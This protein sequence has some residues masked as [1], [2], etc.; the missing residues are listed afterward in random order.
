[1]GNGFLM[2]IIPCPVEG[3]DQDNEDG[4]PVYYIAL[5]DVWYGEH[6]IKRAAVK[7]N[8]P[9]GHKVFENFYLAVALCDDYNLPNLPKNRDLWELEKMN[10]KILTWVGMTFFLDYNSVFQVKKKTYS[11]SLNGT[12]E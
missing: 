7:E 2:R 3:C 9:E 1:M 11:P 6:A 10:L 12:K 4:T 8:I 5:P